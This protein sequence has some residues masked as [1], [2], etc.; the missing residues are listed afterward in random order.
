MGERE[1]NIEGI[2]DISEI[3]NQF[4]KALT[5]TSIKLN[6]TFLDAGKGEEYPY[7]YH[8]PKMGISIN[9]ELSYSNSTIKG[10]FRKSKKS[11]VSSVESNIVL[12]VVSIPKKT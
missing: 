1:N 10:F 9:L 11:E 2:F 5:Q 4:T 3:L 7:V 6:D 8:I 12:E